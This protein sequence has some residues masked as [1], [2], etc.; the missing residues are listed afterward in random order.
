MLLAA[1]QLQNEPLQNGIRLFNE[2]QFFHCHEVLEEAWVPETGP[3]RI[4]LQSLIH[5][6]VGFYHVQR[7]NPAGASGQL[8]KGLSKLARYLPS[9]EG[10]DTARLHRDA[11]AAL[12]SIEGDA[13]E[14]E[15]P[16]IHISPDSQCGVPG[17]T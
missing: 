3:R 2:R 15:Y 17:R 6:A 11:R 4:F 12:Q 16:Q 8:R 10:I 5:L 1:T 13:A 9:C 7:K 14:F